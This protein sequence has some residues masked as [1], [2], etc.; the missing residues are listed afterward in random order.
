MLICVK[1]ESKQVDKIITNN[2]H[3]KTIIIRNTENNPNMNN[4]TVKCMANLIQLLNLYIIRNKAITGKH[5]SKLDKLIMLQIYD[6]Q[7]VTKKEMKDAQ[8]SA[9]LYK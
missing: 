3:L 8:T 1:V 5:L 4:G 9:S 6:C 7:N 2:P